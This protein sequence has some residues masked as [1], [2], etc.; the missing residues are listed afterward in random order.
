MTVQTPKSPVDDLH[1]A[2][3]TVVP[4]VLAGAEV[5]A[6]ASRMDAVLAEDEAAWGADRL[7]A[8][9]QWGAL[10]NLADRGVEFERLLDTAV[11]HEVAAEVIGG[12][13]LL[14]SYDGLVLLPGEGR[15]PWDFHTD[16]LA[17]CG[18]AFPADLSPGVNCL[19]AVDPSGPENGATWLVPGSHRSVAR[20]P[21]P[22][23]LAGLAVQ[24]A[25]RPGDLLLFDAR[26]WH[27]AGRNDSAARR[28]LIKIEL[29]QPWLRTQLDYPRSVRPEVLA[30]LTPRARAAIGE[31]L[32]GSVEEFW[33]AMENRR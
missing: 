11:L 13:Y 19:V 2:G 29:V 1:T 27:C 20:D 16:L 32:P 31:P 15:F 17:L 4:E 10:R 25:L 6:L 7:R 24:P 12:R 9:G 21:D 22:E 8:I 18:T 30:R 14:H 33:L 5:D 26:I 3:Y 28:R 23:L